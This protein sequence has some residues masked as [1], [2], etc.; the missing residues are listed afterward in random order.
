MR[1]L[2]HF[3]MTGRKQA[4]LAVVLLG[5]IPL[6][7]LLNPV[8]VALVMMRKGV[9][10]GMLILAWALLPISVWAVVG[11]IVPL[12]ML[13]GTSGLAWL[14]RKTESW[15][16]TLLAA[17]AIGVSVE[18]YMRLQPAVLDL[19]FQQL[20]LYLTSDTLQGMQLEELRELM[21]SFIGAVYMFLAICLLMLARWM[22]AALFNPGG[23]KQ[24]FHQLRI[25]QK[26]GL[27]LVALMLLANFAIVLPPAWAMYLLLPLVFAGVSLLH[28]VVA[29][30][31]LSSMWLVVFYALIMLPIVVEL[32]ALLALI[33]SWYDFRKRFQL[34]V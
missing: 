2:A 4:I 24:E 14:L 31:K 5:L 15:E 7:N 1:G 23:F 3:V 13:L 10:E 27:G 25:K 33:D 17:I 32:V 30:K 19:V 16:F 20:E 6:V 11:D 9:Q 26:A 12:I 21:T 28:A 22:Q 8:V 29:K 34:T 18:I